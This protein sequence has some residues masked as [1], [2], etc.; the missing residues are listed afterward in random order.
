MQ[1]EQENNE[2]NIV[3][4]SSTK[5]E[6]SSFLSYKYQIEKR[7]QDNIIKEDISGDILLDLADEDFKKIGLKKELIKKIKNYLGQI[8]ANFPEKKIEPTINTSST[9]EEVKGFFEKN[10]GFKIESELDGKKLLELN[11]KD[12]QN[13]GLSIGQRKKLEKYINYFNPEEKNFKKKIKKGYETKHL[14]RLF[15]VNQLIQ[16]HEEIM[17]AQDEEKYAINKHFMS[18]INY[19]TLNKISDFGINFKVNKELDSI[20]NI[21]N[22]LELL[23][24]ENSVD[25]EHIYNANR[26]LN[27]IELSPGLYKIEKD[28]NT[29]LN[30]D[31]ISLYINLTGNL[32]IANTLL[33]CNEQTTKEE[34]ISFFYRAIYNDKPILFTISNLELLSL[35]TIQKIFK[36]LKKLYIAKN[37]IIKSYLI[38]IYEKMDSSLSKDLDELIPYKNIL[39]K[40]YTNL[41]NKRNKTLDEIVIYS[42]LYSGYGK[43]TEIMYKIMDKKGYYAY[44][45]IGGTL[46][47]DY[48]I[49]KIKNLNI[50][51]QEDKNIYLHFDLSDTK[52]DELMNEILF[53]LIILRYLDSNKEIFYLGHDINIFIEIP[54]GTID[55]EKKFQILTLFTKESIDSLRPLRI[56][57]Y[58]NQIGQSPISIVGECLLSYEENKI[59][60]KNLDLEMPINRDNEEKYEQIINKYFNIENQNYYKKMKFIKILALQFKKMSE[61]LHLNYDIAFMNGMHETI[62]KCRKAVVKNFIEST[63]VFI[64]SPYDRILFKKQIESVNIYDKYDQ[65]KEIFS[66]D[67]TKINLVF[68][69]L[70]GDSFSIISNADKDDDEYKVLQDLWNSNNLNR[71]NLLPLIDY[72]KLSHDE[73]LDE[74]KKIFSLDLLK[75]DE[76]KEICEKAGNY[77]FVCDNFLKIFRIVLNVEAKIPII[78]M[79]ETSKGKIKIVD[80]VEM[81]ATLY[82]KGKMNCQKKEI[83]E[84]TTEEEIVAFIEKITEENQNS[85]NDLVWVFFNEL[86]KC[87]SLGIITE[88]MCKQTLLGKKINDN[89]VFL[90]SYY[91]KDKKKLNDSEYLMNPLSHSLL[92][93]LFDLGSLGHEDV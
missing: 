67:N 51:T 43:S 48:T 5:E 40:N 12:F 29:D 92:N 27:N 89:F 11:D 2:S 20:E 44:L 63:K 22:Y 65:K 55:F 62:K 7:V 30:I 58:V 6:V 70:D 36:K 81:I 37:G 24:K 13:L 14:L 85:D 45:P 26:I 64:H 23:L 25:I 61:N 69:N 54:Q 1:K 82:G 80:I 88:I 3:S 76:I 73:Y 53:K 79:A 28:P 33:L 39:G 19:M 72:R 71:K 47:R 50:K 84:D 56:E 16:L 68:F 9:I 74:I 34:I 10:I 18:L 52:Q 32:P 31:L 35:S 86:N 46:T 15:F 93:F 60:K 66:F 75:K 87:N 41:P 91:L 21:N 17:K 42:S 49:K 8:K 77:I 90:G 59:D 83:N 4:S 57:T 38:L 78:F